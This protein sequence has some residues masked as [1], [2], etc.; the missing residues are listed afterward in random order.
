VAGRAGA[1][2]ALCFPCGC[3]NDAEAYEL[4]DRRKKDTQHR[5]ANKTQCLGFDASLIG[6]G[7]NRGKSKTGVVPALE[8][9]QPGVL[10]LRSAAS[11]EVASNA[12]KTNAAKMPA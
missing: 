1:L 5:K 2:V 3:G 11:F 6:Q 10:S 8:R 12:S 7:M 4:Q 9:F